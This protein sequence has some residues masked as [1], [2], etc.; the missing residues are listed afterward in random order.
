[1]IGADEKRVE[2]WRPMAQEIA[3]T[4]GQPVRL[5]RFN[6]REDSETIEP[7]GKP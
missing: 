4:T 1:M 6:V 7:E 2:Q 5:V 3:N